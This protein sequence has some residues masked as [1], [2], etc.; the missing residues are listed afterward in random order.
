M[1]KGENYESK[2]LKIHVLENDNSINVTWIG[3]SVDRQPSKFL[4]PILINTMEEAK[5]KTKRIILDFRKLEYMNSS[6]IT[7]VIKVLDRAKKS[8][9]SLTILYNKALKWQEL[10]FS[11]LEL[12]VTKDNRI[13]I[14]GL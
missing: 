11:A 7:P 2:D 1:K 5:Q 9:I 10:N 8:I 14:K 4:S 12:F 3:K 13:E 6:T